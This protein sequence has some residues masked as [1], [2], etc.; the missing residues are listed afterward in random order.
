MI[1]L[2]GLPWCSLYLMLLLAPQYIHSHHST[3]H[4][5]CLIPVNSFVAFIPAVSTLSQ[6]VTRCFFIMQATSSQFYV[7][8][9]G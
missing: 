8:L 1:D 9:T 5:L 3:L 4:I 2:L 7:A 6:L